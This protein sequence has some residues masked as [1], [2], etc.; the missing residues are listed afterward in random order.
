MQL[1]N[2]GYRITRQKRRIVRNGG[3][4][5]TPFAPSRI[6]IFAKAAHTVALFRHECGIACLLIRSNRSA[7]PGDLEALKFGTPLAR[8]FGH[9]RK[10]KLANEDDDDTEAGQS[11]PSTRRPEL[12]IALLWNSCR[13]VE[14]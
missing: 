6:T 10:S 1:K 4:T 9:G 2:R 5:V 3:R 14:G 7:V 13:A 8:P 12:A 11:P